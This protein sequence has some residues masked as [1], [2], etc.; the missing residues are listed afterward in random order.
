MSRARA[1]ETVRT[2]THLSDDRGATVERGAVGR[3]LEEQRRGHDGTA[4][5]VV[6]WQDGSVSEVP[7][8][9]LERR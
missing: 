6:R 9:A 7:T 1:G 2:T 3:V 4:V 5:Q 8:K